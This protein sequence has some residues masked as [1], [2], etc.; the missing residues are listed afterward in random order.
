MG[1]DAENARRYAEVSASLGKLAARE[2][3]AQLKNLLLSMSSDCEKLA[4]YFR[5]SDETAGLRC[6]GVG[7]AETEER[8]QANREI[9]AILMKL[10]K[11]WEVL[12]AELDKRTSA[13]QADLID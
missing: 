2:S 7:I 9:N 6:A 10:Q 11:Q 5:A 8:L 4:R 13:K 3:D 12:A 1:W